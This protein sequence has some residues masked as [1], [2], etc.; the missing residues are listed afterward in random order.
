A[1]ATTL[2]S[3]VARLRR[4]LGDDGP[5]VVTQAPGYRLDL[6][7][8]TFDVARFE[9]A[10]AEAGR[11]LAQ[12]DP[13][14]AAE[15]ARAALACWRGDAYAESA[16]EDWARP[17]A[18]RLA[19]LRTVAQERLVEALL[20]AGRA[21]EAIPLIEGALAEHPYRESFRSH[22]AVAL[23]RAGRQT[24]ALRSLHEFR[25]VLAEDLGL[26]PSPTLVELE[27]QVLDHH[28][29]LAAGEA[30]GRPLRGYRLVERLGSGRDGT[31]H[32]ARLP[33]VER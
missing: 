17:E 21:D 31:V 27:R 25:T 9:A 32:A 13:H 29:D 20:A 26:D 14:G 1:A 2:R 10:L 23:Y 8:V 18:E 4:A 30:T 16:D 12:A 11:R 22:H 5:T 19:E 24:D 33:G 28:P 7:P 6:G 15:Q 3:Y